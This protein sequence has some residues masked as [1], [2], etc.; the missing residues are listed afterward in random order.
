MDTADLESV[1]IFDFLELLKVYKIQNDRVKLFDAEVT[2]Q[3]MITLNQ[4][5]L[6]EDS[7]LMTFFKNLEAMDITSY[8]EKEEMILNKYNRPRLLACF[9]EI[10]HYQR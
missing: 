1:R 8:F 3:H 7:Q 6:L 2:V 9:N 5:N 4:Q 10:P